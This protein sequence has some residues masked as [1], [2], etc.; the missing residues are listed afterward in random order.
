M[1]LSEKSNPELI[2]IIEEDYNENLQND[3][4]DELTRRIDLK[5]IKKMAIKFNDE[6]I[7]NI[8]K[9]I[10]IVDF[11]NLEIPKSKLLSEKTLK[12]IFSEI[13]Q[14]HI[15]RRNGLYDNVITI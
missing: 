2:E 1:N 3:A 13:Y 7:K 8:F 12:K 15:E 9:T 4:F 14:S 6:R 5:Q 10:G 11:E